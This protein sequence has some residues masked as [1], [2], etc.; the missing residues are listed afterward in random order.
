MSDDT[1]PA[2][3]KDGKDKE[4]KGKGKKDKGGGR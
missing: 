3:I 1:N 4:K 2:M